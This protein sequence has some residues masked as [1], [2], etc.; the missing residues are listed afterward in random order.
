MP[1]RS[2]ATHASCASNSDIFASP[3]RCFFSSLIL[4]GLRLKVCT[5]LTS[6]LLHF[7]RA[8]ETLAG[9]HQ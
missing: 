2:K 8:V 3:H 4:S 7:P 5:M 9:L 6:M 1:P